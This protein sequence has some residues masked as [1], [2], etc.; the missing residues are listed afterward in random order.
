MLASD[1]THLSAGTGDLTAHPLLLSLDNIHSKARRNSS[2]HAFLLLALL[3]KPQ[4]PD[5]LDPS[6]ARA[7]RDRILHKCIRIVCAPFRE[8]SKHGQLMSDP[9]GRLR[10]CFT[11]LSMYMV[12]YPEATK[13]A[14]VTSFTSPVT[15]AKTK[16]LGDSFRHERR[17]W[18]IT[19]KAIDDTKALADPIGNIKQYVKLANK[20]RLTGATELLWD[21]WEH[22]E[23]AVVLGFDILH[24]GHKYWKDHPFSWA[25]KS[26][27]SLEIDA[28]YRLLHSRIGWR[29]FHMG[30][31]SLKKTG[32]RDHRDM[33]RYLLAVLDGAVPPQFISLLRAYLD[34]T[35]IAQKTELTE[36]DFVDILNL[37]H[38]FHSKKDIVHEKGYR[39]VEGFIIPKLE[40]QHHIVPTMIANGHLLGCST[41]IS[42][43]EHI[44]QVKDPFEYTNRKDFEKQMVGRLDKLERLRHFDLVTAIEAENLSDSLRDRNSNWL[45]N[46]STIQNLRHAKQANHKDYFAVMKKLESSNLAPKYRNRIRTFKGSSFTAIHLTREAEIAEISIQQAAALFQLPDLYDAIREYF[47]SIHTH[48]NLSSSDHES[49]DSESAGLAISR[50]PN[51]VPASFS[52][53]F[54]KIRVWFAIRVQTRS[55]LEPGKA[56]KTATICTQ[57][58]SEEWPLGRSDFA[59]FANNLTKRFKGH[60]DLKGKYTEISKSCPTLIT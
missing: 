5:N 42:E 46:L 11:V 50:C 57:P 1:A 43:H 41:D 29:H 59:L 22:C 37:L 53:D 27:G 18:H 34:Y 15:M 8:M 3:P 49:S 23:P 44:Q 36:A 4:F 48:E 32:G 31:S 21:G 40:L 51:A 39:E 6:I 56:N 12:D 10:N 19:K 55:L 47:Y 17:W 38:E 2:N 33:Q 20:Q 52:L 13:L 16:A 28:R 60:A 45:L 7:L 9:T 54:E 58:P 24:S 30:V 35:Y 25:V 14:G 26:I